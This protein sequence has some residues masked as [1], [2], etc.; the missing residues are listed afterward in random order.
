MSI[1]L[2]LFLSLILLKQQKIASLSFSQELASG[3]H[4][5]QRFALLDFVWLC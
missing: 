5:R 1:I 2:L 3:Q 4:L